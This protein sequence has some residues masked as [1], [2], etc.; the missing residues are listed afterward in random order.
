MQPGGPDLGGG[1]RLDL[2]HLAPAG[3]DP[4]HEAVVKGQRADGQ[5]D[6]QH[7][8]PFGEVHQLRAAAAHVHQ[9][10]AVQRC[11]LKGAVVVKFRFLLAGKDP[12][13]KA[14]LRPDGVQD[15]LGVGDVPQGCRAEG[16]H[17]VQGDLLR[18][19][20]QLGQHFH[21]L[22]DALL[23]HFP[24]GGDI[25]RKTRG[26]FVVQH[27]MDGSVVHPIDH[28]A[29][30]VGTNVNDTVQHSPF[31]LAILIII[32]FTQEISRKSR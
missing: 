19:R 23:A 9:Q 20:P 30:R 15:L 21:R 18:D 7:R 13:R 2:P 14:A 31:L 25:A 10:S 1:L 28:E 3:Q 26:E 6:S 12:H 5:R 29:N 16:E 32:Q 24:L 17:P 27:R 4:V 11:T 8:L 22:A